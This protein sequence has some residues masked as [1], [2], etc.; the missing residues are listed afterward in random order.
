MS[1]FVTPIWVARKEQ[2]PHPEGLNSQL[3]ALVA[4]LSFDGE[5]I[6]LYN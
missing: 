2:F 1:A 3:Y 5:E 4:T 6:D